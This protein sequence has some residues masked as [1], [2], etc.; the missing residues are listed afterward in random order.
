MI[1]TQFL[2][3]RKEILATTLCSSEETLS[4][5]KE[6]VKIIK[7]EIA[8]IRGAI[9]ELDELIEGANYASS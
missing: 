1:T 2:E 3:E 7:H 5:L 6:R 4:S 8:N 9:L